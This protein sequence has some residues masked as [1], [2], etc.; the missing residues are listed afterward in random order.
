MV[1]TKMDIRYD[2]YTHYELFPM[3]KFRALEVS[4]RWQISVLW[5][6]P[7]AIHLLA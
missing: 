7:A 5:C 4:L 6:P 1:M 3:R 2:I